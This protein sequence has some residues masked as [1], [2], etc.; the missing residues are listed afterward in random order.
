VFDTADAEGYLKRRFGD[1]NGYVALAFK[2]E[3]KHLE[4]DNHR[5]LWPSNAQL[6]GQEVSYRLYSN[7][8]TDVYICPTLRSSSEKRSVFNEL[9]GTSVFADLDGGSVPDALLP[10]TELVNSGTPGHYHAY[11]TLTEPVGLDRIEALNYALKNVSNG[12][13]KW[14]EN[15][16]LR[17]PGTI[18]TK[19]GNRVYTEKLAEKTIK[20]ETLEAYLK[21]FMPC[22][23]AMLSIRSREAP[24]FGFTEFPKNIPAYIMQLLRE[25]PIVGRRSHQAYH[26]INTC[27]EHGYSYSEVGLLAMG[28]EPTMQKFDNRL[29]W[30]VF[31]TMNQRLALQE[32]V[33]SW[34]PQK[35]S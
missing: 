19:N 30:I 20:A 17:L 4:T 22:E 24:S 29:E 18:N 2:I 7:P 12:D 8:Q 16:I 14:R 13:H 28:H 27:F 35:K 5:F 6:L 21:N 9:K 10:W 34:L 32:N 31:K 25:D 3:G 23:E 1:R 11:M 26:F 33:M 15:T